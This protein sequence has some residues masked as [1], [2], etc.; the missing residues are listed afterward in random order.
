MHILG[1][2]NLAGHVVGMITGYL[3]YHTQENGKPIGNNKIFSLLTWLMWCALPVIIYVFWLGRMFY[4]DG[5]EVSLAFKLLYAA[6][7]RVLAGSIATSIII[8]LVF[9]LNGTLCSILEW[10][11]WVIP[12]RLSYAVLLV[13]MNIVSVIL[14]TKTQLGHSSPFFAVRNFKL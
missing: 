1:H 10:R 14:G 8:G 2:N 7:Q 9:R 5:Y 12:S 3:V 4:V 13:H 6:T 11:G